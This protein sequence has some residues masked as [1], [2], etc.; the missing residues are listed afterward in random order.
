MLHRVLLTRDSSDI[1]LTAMKV[2]RQIVKSAEE[3]TS[4]YTKLFH[5]VVYLFT[6][7]LFMN[8]LLYI[9]VAQIKAYMEAFFFRWAALL[10]ISDVTFQVIVCSFLAVCTF[11]FASFALFLYS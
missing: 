1:Q 10:F 3:S 4:R 8:F 7:K 9:F 5:P 2:V 11:R 6:P